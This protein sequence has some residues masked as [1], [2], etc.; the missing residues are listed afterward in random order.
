MRKIALTFPGEIPGTTQE[1]QAPSGIPSALQGGLQTSGKPLVQTGINLVFY[2]GIILAI[3]FILISGI[4]FITSGGDSNKL[5]NAKKRLIYAIIGLV[6][7]TLSF[8]IV[9]TILGIRGGNTGV[10]F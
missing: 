5:A 3:I 4:N 1:V 10:F 8:F 2:L 7:V 9:R 6:L